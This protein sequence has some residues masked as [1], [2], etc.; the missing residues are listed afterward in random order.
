MLVHPY[1]ELTSSANRRY[2]IGG[3]DARIIMGND[4]TA[5][6]RLW[7]E[8]RGE[9]EPEDLSDNL[10][11]QLGL[12]TEHLNRTWYEREDREGRQKCPMPGPPPRTSVDGCHA[13]WGRRGDWH[14]VR[15]KIHAA[16]VVF[17]RGGGRKAHA[18]TP[19]Q[20]VGHQRHRFGA[21][22]YYRRRQVG[23]D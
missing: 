7:R 6:Q 4:E 13:G 18:P 16:V 15:S 21:F 2:F 20:Y 10:I 22:D 1:R 14:G 12:V 8:K 5:L 19:T 17:R 9:T 3:S 11:V 23:R